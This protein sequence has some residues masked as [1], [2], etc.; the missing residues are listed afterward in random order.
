M[1]GKYTRRPETFAWIWNPWTCKYCGRKGIKGGSWVHERFCRDR[2]ERFWRRVDKSAGPDGCWLWTGCKDKW[3]YGDLQFLG[4]HLQAHRVAWILTR[5]HP[6]KMDCLHTCHNASCCNPAHLYL[7]TDKE[8]ARDRVAAGRHSRGEQTNKNKLTTADV[9]A[10][11]RDFRKYGHHKK[12]RS[13]TAELAAKY[14]V[15]KG[16][17]TYIIYRG[18]WKH[19]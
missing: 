13:N 12:A 16:A 5:G 1:K 3:G 4:K 14:G 6:G 15:G 9:R 17:I 18:G 19:V 2:A 7:G 8:N 10:I 11:R